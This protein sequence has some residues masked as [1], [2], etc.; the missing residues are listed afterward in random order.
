MR[1]SELML[2]NAPPSI[3]S[4]SP[5]AVR[6]FLICFVVLELLLSPPFCCSANLLFLRP[7]RFLP[8]PSRS[9][10][11]VSVVEDSRPAFSDPSRRRFFI[12]DGFD[13]LFSPS[14][15]VSPLTFLSG[16]LKGLLEG[17]SSVSVVEDSRPA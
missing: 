16:L 3:P 2:V 7:G 1:L 13:L 5:E 15:S 8:S 17:V 4:H 11:S 10:S 6:F 12:G 14:S 9:E